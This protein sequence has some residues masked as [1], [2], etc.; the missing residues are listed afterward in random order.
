MKLCSWLQLYSLA[1]HAQ[2]TAYSFFFFSYFT[3][4]LS[5]VT[6]I[7]KLLMSGI[8]VRDQTAL[9]QQQVCGCKGVEI[10][11]SVSWFG[12]VSLKGFRGY[13]RMHAHTHTRSLTHTHGNLINKCY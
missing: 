11:S 10:S 8:R 7:L 6:I 13:T 2:T 12:D 9:T 5:F 4:F 1:A 3:A